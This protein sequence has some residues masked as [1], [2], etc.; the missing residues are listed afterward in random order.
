[1]A[2]SSHMH[3]MTRTHIDMNWKL[4]Q[5]R[6]GYEITGFVIWNFCKLQKINIYFTIFQSYLRKNA[7][8]VISHLLKT[9]WLRW[10]EIFYR[11]VKPFETNSKSMYL[12]AHVIVNSRHFDCIELFLTVCVNLFT[13]VKYTGWN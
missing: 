8:H 4:T 6:T 1:M 10:K 13:A 12:S 9:K 11:N 7:L 5:W 3:G 2:S